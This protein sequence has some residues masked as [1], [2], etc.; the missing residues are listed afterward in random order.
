MSLNVTTAAKVT[1]EGAVLRGLEFIYGTARD[2]ENFAAY[3]YD[4][5]FC[6]HWVA[7]TSRGRALRR[8]AR[9]MAAL[10]NYSEEI[11]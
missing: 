3:G 11:A 8:T 1:A 5:T 2:P 4:Y 7:A 9:K 10:H 6:L